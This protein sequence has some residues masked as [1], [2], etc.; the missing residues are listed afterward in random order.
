MGLAPLLAPMLQIERH[1]VRLPAPAGVQAILLTSATALPALPASFHATKLLAVGDAT[2]G[3]ALT[4]G[5]TAVQSAA[6]DAQA[7]LA[8]VAATCTPS[9]GTLLLP[10]AADLAADLTTP[11]RH[12]GFRVLRRIVYRAR[13]ATFLPPDIHAALH[14]GTIKHVLVYS[15][16]SARAFV[17]LARGI[18]LGGV[19]ALAI[20]AATAAALAPLRWRCIRVAP[21]PNQ[22]ALLELLS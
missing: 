19:A 17:R 20:S 7:L 5:F 14:A 11:L 4:A 22:D 10:G 9:A 2:A 12:L 3:K 8:L 1:P 18:P 15:P 6:G 21:R 13:P 16:A